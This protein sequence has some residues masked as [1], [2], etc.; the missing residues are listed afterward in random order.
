MD[1]EKEIK[2]AEKGALLSIL[3]Y[4]ILSLIKLFVAYKG[5]SEALKADGLNN[6]LTA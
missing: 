5:D 2:L 3:A 6:M 1:R 4:V